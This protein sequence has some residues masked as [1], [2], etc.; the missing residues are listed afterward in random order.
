MLGENGLNRRG[1]RRQTRFRLCHTRPVRHV[2]KGSQ[3]KHERNSGR[4]TLSLR[5][6]ALGWTVERRKEG[7]QDDMLEDID[8]DRT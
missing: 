3:R 1:C 5:C 7:I 4:L 8:S 2:M 6:N